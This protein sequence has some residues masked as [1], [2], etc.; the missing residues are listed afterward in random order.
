MLSLKSYAFPSFLVYVCH[1]NGDIII[2]FA[3]YDALYELTYTERR[4]TAC[5]RHVAAKES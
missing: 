3:L 2:S 4:K 1:Y 5:C